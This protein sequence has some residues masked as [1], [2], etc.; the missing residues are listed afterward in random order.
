MND[1]ELMEEAL[2]EARKALEAGEVPVGAIVALDG[3]VVGRGHNEREA[4]LSIASHAEIEALLSAEK[5]LGRVRLSECTLYVTLEPCLMCAGAI[6][7]SRIHRLVY[8][9]DDPKAGAI[10]SRF[11]V[12]DEVTDDGVPLLEI[13]SKKEESK[14]LLQEFFAKRRG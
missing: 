9:L 13:G 7:Q 4:K 11:H 5:E 6:I 1:V 8:A 3:K 10:R 12:F 2:K 14:A